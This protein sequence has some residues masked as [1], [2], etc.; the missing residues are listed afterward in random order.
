MDKERKLIWKYFLQQKFKETLV[1]IKIL[2]FF[3]LGCLILILV[4]YWTIWGLN[5]ISNF[6]KSHV[7]IQY[8]IE[9]IIL[10]IF[11]GM[12]LFI[13]FHVISEFLKENWTKAEIRAK[14]ELNKGVLK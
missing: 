4:V 5:F 12:I 8:I 7:I 6:M 13:F 14:E 11:G 3:V 9:G 1:G 2:L 10:T